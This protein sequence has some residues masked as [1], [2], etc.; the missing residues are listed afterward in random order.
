VDTAIWVKISKGK[1]MT[2]EQRQQIA[3]FRYGLIVPIVMKEISKPEKYAISK[4]ILSQKYNIP[5]SKKGTIKERTFRRYIIDELMADWE[6]AI[7]GENIF[8]IDPLK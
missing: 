1:N 3:L 5:C 7:D 6:L 8:K 4:K 2:D